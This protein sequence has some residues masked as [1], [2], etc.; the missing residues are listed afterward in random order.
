MTRTY[1]TLDRFYP[2]F[3]DAG[4]IARMVPL[5]IGTVQ[6]RAKDISSD[7]ARAE[8]E[9]GLAV[10]RAHGCR[11][12]VNDFWREAIAAGAD[13]IHLGQEDLAGAD[14]AAIKAA[15][16]K[17]GVSTH[18]E[19][20]LA[21]ALA[22]DPDYIALGPVWETRLKVMKWAP[23]GLDRVRRWK[24]RIGAIPLVGIGGITPERADSV[25]AAGADSCAVIT[26]FV[27]HADPAARIAHWVAWAR[28]YAK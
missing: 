1:E 28:T 20:E 24:D 5:G 18:D 14:V 8:I 19:A 10:C 12:I 21:I 17:L 4:W 16:L 11:L 13:W 25:L 9:R 27:T 22:V 23:Q 3:P 2:I 26:D 15:G 7:T 6:L